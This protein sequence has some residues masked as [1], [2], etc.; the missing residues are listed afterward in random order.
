MAF[1]VLHIVRDDTVGECD[2]MPTDLR[3]LRKPQGFDKT[4]AHDRKVPQL[5]KPT[6]AFAPFTGGADHGR[7]R[8]LPPGQAQREEGRA[9]HLGVQGIEA[10]HGH[11]GQ[12]A[13]R[14]LVAVLG[15]GSAAAHS[16][17]FDVPGTYRM[18]CLVHPTTMG[19][20]VR[21]R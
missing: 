1:W 6:G 16:F 10:A 15:A 7:R 8:L 12:R 13:A 3:E 4:P 9:G 19:Q 21:V 17:N 5:D 14:L 11:R 2:P 18:T 20:T